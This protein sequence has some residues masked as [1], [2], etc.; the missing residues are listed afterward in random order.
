MAL[1]LFDGATG[2]NGLG[3]YGD[4]GSINDG[5][6]HHLVHTFDRVKGMVTYLDGV[7]AHYVARVG[8][9]VAAAG[10]V[11][12]GH[13]ATIGQ[14]PTGRYP[15]SGYAD[16]D[17]LGVWRRALTALEAAS[18]YMAAVTNGLSFTGGP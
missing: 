12:T 13:P 9:S 7:E 3:V 2:A 6:W 17:D 5:N 16:I 18:I 11:D 8:S 4:A 14:D 1:S 15:E 10:D